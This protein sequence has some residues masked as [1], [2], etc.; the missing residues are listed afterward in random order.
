MLRYLIVPSILMTLALASYSL[1]VWSERLQRYLRP[2][3]LAAFWLGLAF[4]S[5]GTYRMERLLEAGMRDP[6]HTVLGL[7][8]FLLMSAHVMWAT[9]AVWRGTEEVRRGFHRFSLLVWLVWLVP[10]LGGM[11]AGVMR[12]LAA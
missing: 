11:I 8:A 9:W 3:H 12:G 4:D 1:A 7:A 6:L 10:Y 5:A 2:W